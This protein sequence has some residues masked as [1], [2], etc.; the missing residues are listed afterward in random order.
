MNEIKIFE[1]ETFGKIR[2]AEINGEPW[3][4]LADVCKVLEIGNSRMVANRLDEDELMSAKL[5]SG[6]QKRE[7][8]VINESGLYAVIL[9]SDKPQAKP[10]RKWVTSE[11]IP[12]IRKYGAYGTYRESDYSNLS[13]QLQFLIQLEK[14]QNRLEKRLDTVCETLQVRGSNWRKAT[15]SLIN[16]IAS[17]SGIEQR[18]LY[19]VIYDEL[20]LRAGVDLDRR[21]ANLEDR[22]YERGV[23]ESRISRLN[24]I[25]VIAEDRKLI[26]IYIAIVKET[27]I[28]YN[29][30]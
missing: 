8:T 19:L 2:V 14:K 4:V 9:R 23:S 7:M 28:K 13:P 25:D 10:F 15:H 21:L 26:E 1:N 20:E 11:I 3:W 27:A 6:G 18:E 16:R 30:E 29:A 5:T 12:S 17:A 22:L 24:Y